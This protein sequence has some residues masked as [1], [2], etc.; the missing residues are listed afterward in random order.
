LTARKNREAAEAQDPSIYE[1]DALYDS[2]KPQPK[3][4]KEDEERRPRYMTGLIAA[5]TVRK[6]DAIIAEE[7]KFAREREAEGEEFADKEKFVTSAYK[8]QQEENRR[9]QEEEARREEKD[10]K[11]NQTSG[12]AA[13]YRN[14]LKSGDEE[15]AEIMRAAEE[16]IKSGVRDD[17]GEQETARTKTDAELA[18]EI[19]ARGGSIQINEEGEVVDKRQLLRGGLNI[20]PT[21][22]SGVRKEAGPAAP[23]SADTSSRPR[24]RGVF[25]GGGKRAMVERQS[26]MM[27][28]QLAETL[29]RSRDAEEEERRSTIERMTKSRK[30]EGEVSSARERY[31]AR[32]REAEAAKKNGGQE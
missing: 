3:T 14:L 22:K 5:A 27:E 2:M 28:E 16:R 24:G 7:K 30:T 26:K 23:D 17:D 29:K 9:I 12:M 8:K 15:H 4:D 18:K 21:V 10:A 13:F 32:K 31:L 19:N 11:K 25:A 20:L 1:Y 6:R